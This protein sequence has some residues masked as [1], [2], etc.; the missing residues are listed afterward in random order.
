MNQIIFKMQRI[1]EMIF[2]S[3]ITHFSFL[4][5]YMNQL[6]LFLEEDTFQKNSRGLT[7]VCIGLV[8]QIHPL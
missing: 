2:V 4:R 7:L 3:R 6:K 1:C 5:E 8:L